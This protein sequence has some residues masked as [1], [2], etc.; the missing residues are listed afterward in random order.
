MRPRDRLTLGLGAAILALSVLGVGG[1]VRP[2]LIA[3]GALITAALAVQVTSRRAA[4]LTP[5]VALLAVAAALT[6]LQ[7]VPLPA[8]VHGA[9]DAEGAALQRDGA[10]LLGEALGAAPLSRDPAGTAHGL[11]LLLLLLGTSVVAVRIAGSE[12]G[13]LAL[14]GGV[15]GVGVVTAVVTAVHQAVGARALWGLYRPELSTPTLLGPLLNPNHLGCLLAMSA[16]AAG[17]LAFHHPLRPAVRASWALAAAVTTAAALYTQSRGAALALLVGAAVCAGTLLGQRLRGR[18]DSEAPPRLSVNSVAI[19][20]VALC[21]LALL[22]YTS[23]RGVS[24]QLRATESHEWQ[25]P[26]SKFAAWRSALQLVGETP[27]LGVGRGAFE[28]SFTRVHPAAG[29]VTFSHP[30]NEYVQAVVEWGV[31]GALLL[32]ALGGWLAVSAA[33]RWRTGA[34]CSAALGGATVVAVQSVVDFGLE[35]PGLAIPSLALA[36]SLVHVPLREQPAR[37][38][39]KAALGRAALA[40]AVLVAT[41]LLATSLT[42]LPREDHALLAATRPAEE[43]VARAVA[44][45]HPHDYLAFTH[46]AQ[47]LAPSAPARA[48]A[49]YNHALRLHPTHPGVHR[50]VAR[51]LLARGASRQAALEYATALRN[52]AELGPLLREVVRAFPEPELAAS[53]I[54]TDYPVPE[55]VARALVAAEAPAVALAYLARVAQVRPGAPRLGELL[56]TAAKQAGD[57]ALMEQAA[58]LRVRHEPTA[59][60]L[61]ALGRL[62]VEQGRLDEAAALLTDVSAVSG[63][64]EELSAAW[65]LSCDVAISRRQWATAATCLAALR[66]SPYAG[67]LLL[68][69]ARRDAQVRAGQRAQGAGADEGAKSRGAG[70]DEDAGSHGA[71]GSGGAAPPR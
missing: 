57:R 26:Q 40:A 2:V 15:A 24:E 55:H 9:L 48:L 66:D 1:A 46:L 47:A 4:R 8:G 38:R 14:V 20:V 52:A 62:L 49:L 71:A 12:R 32:A 30:E 69:L 53:A 36:A 45:R 22:V 28:T 16:V 7:L 25:D 63:R 11:A 18:A 54:P 33:R 31:V 50:A 56:Y 21:V 44:A 5:L 39:R 19:G 58:R 65:L 64:P 35:L 27:W 23:G 41:C 59:A 34:L 51:L 68:E 61:L 29:R 37:E 60:S 43:P 42:R 67:K 13:R 10:A 3:L 70:T 17:G 6:A